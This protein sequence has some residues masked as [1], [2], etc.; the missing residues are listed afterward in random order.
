MSAPKQRITKYFYVSSSDTKR[1]KIQPDK[2]KIIIP[3]I[4]LAI[5]GYNQFTDTKAFEL[6]MSQWV[7]QYGG[8]PSSV[9]GGEVKGADLLGKQWA[10]RNYIPH[11]SKPC[12]S[13]IGYHECNARIINEATH[14]IAFSLNDWRTH[15]ATLLA[16]KKGIPCRIVVIKR[17]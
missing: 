8:Y 14:V 15:H 4:H 9:I 12:T 5:I 17:F 16:K 11:D 13:G 7:E 10:S 1:Q 2:S 3:D 6:S